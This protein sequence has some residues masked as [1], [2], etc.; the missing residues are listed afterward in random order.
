VNILGLAAVLGIVRGHN[1]TIGVKSEPGKGT[2]FKIL[3]PVPEDIH[4]PVIERSAVAEDGQSNGTILVALREDVV[5]ETTKPMLEQEGFIVLTAE[6]GVETIEIYRKHL[7]K[8]VCV[9]LDRSLRHH[10]ASEQTFMSYVSSIPM[11]K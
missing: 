11:P 10:L 4:F 9:L 2:T 7:D 3:F 8:I 5:R 6:D 1:G